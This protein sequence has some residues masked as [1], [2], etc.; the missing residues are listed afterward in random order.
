LQP[1]QTIS[2]RSWRLS[3]S[4]SSRRLAQPV[5]S[6]TS[7]LSV[8][9]MDPVTVAEPIAR[10]YVHACS[11][12]RHKHVL[13]RVFRLLRLCVNVE[14]NCRARLRS[15]NSS[16]GHRVTHP[17]ATA[18][19]KLRADVS[20]A[21][22]SPTSMEQPTTVCDASSDILPSNTPSNRD[23]THLGLLPARS[24]VVPRA[25]HRL[26][27]RTPVYRGSRPAPMFQDHGVNLR[28]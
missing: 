21:A 10:S 18:P 27:H 20:S 23:G 11:A 5:P 14:A 16:P 26:Q 2:R 3:R 25:L 17:S 22:H 9:L 13:I 4:S 7:P 28:V 6:T 8:A 19:F 24:G 12:H 15:L 1:E